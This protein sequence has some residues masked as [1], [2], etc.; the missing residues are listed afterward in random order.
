MQSDI[1]YVENKILNLVRSS[2]ADREGG[3]NTYQTLLETTKSS[4]YTGERVD[5]A[6][7]MG[8]K[9]S[10][11]EAERVELTVNGKPLLTSEYKLENGKVVL[12][13]KFSSPGIYKL[14]GELKFLKNNQL[15]SV[16]VNQE[17]SVINRPNTAVISAVNN[18]VLYKVLPNP[19]SVSIP[20]IPSNSLRVSSN[21]GSVSK[22]GNLFEISI[23][24][25]SKSKKVKISVSGSLDGN[26]ISPPAMEFLVK[27]PPPP[28]ASLKVNNDFYTG[29]KK[30][31]RAY[32]GPGTVSAKFPEWFN[33]N[34]EVLVTGFDV[35]VGNLPSKKVKGNRMSNNSRVLSDIKNSSKGT[36]VS[37]TN[38]KTVT[39]IGG[40]NY[41]LPNEARSF[42]LFIN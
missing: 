31:S 28:E 1:R 41:K 14:E 7:V 24:F 18:N 16:A 11:F 12:N 9:D 23:P 3:L 35:K 21:V 5:A 30:V 4:Y 32:L 22:K 17:F 8:K 15:Q 38:I 39:K 34:L 42:V 25:E 20:G 2:I 6:V 26:T 36:A 29:S 37:I 19:L 10:S 40:K 33:Y 13:K 27:S